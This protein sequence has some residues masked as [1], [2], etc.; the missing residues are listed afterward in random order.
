MPVQLVMCACQSGRDMCKCVMPEKAC[1][2]VSV[3]QCVSVSLFQCFGAL[4]VG[5]L[6]VCAGGKLKLPRSLLR[7]PD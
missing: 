7:R 2:C 3:S 1:K 4:C 5:A 6:G